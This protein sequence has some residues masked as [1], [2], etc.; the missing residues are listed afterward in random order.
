MC[1]LEEKPNI[2]FA[3]IAGHEYI[4]NLIRETLILPKLVPFLFSKSR[5]KPRPWSKIL[6]YGPPGVGKTMIAQAIAAEF[7]GS[8]FW[9]SLS[10]L[11]SKFIGE[12][13]KLI[14]LLFQMA[15]EQ[16]PAIIVF[17]E[18]DSLVR[19]RSGRESETERR[20]KTAF[21][22]QLDRLISETS[23]LVVIGTTNMP[24]EMDIAALRR[25]ERRI[26]V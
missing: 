23:D 15:I 4:K 13:E 24:W 18:M 14:S 7:E 11:T 1:L 17:D 21:L 26:L 5:G 2:T 19:K 20:I 8:C 6:L 3:D 12:S 22:T 16:S 25:F 9:A 10:D